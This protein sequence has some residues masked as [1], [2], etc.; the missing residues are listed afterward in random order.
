M[1][2]WWLGLLGWLAMVWL[3]ACSPGGPDVA[4]IIPTERPTPTLGEVA[5]HPTELGSRTATLATS[6]PGAT[7]QPTVILE[8]TSESAPAVGLLRLVDRLDDPLGYCVDVSGFGV[9]LQLDAPLQAHTCKPGSDDQLF[10]QLGGGLRL[11]RH[12]RCLVAGAT[13]DGSSVGVAQ[14]D[15]GAA[16]QRFGLD[17]DGEIRLVAADGS[18]LCVGVAGG[19]GEPAGGRNHLR[20]DLKLH[21]CDEA[22]PNL[23]R[24]E[25]VKQ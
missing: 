1:T 15:A 24:W 10:A 21:V 16:G 19:S 5:A 14:C 4:A 2:K 6:R 25:L 18:A 12:G 9:N 20:R 17:A 8:P 13:V 7:L 3:V 22:K 11:E 23:I